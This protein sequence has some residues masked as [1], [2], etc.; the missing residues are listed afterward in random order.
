VVLVVITVLAGIVVAVGLAGTTGIVI[1]V[2]LAVLLGLGFAVVAAWITTKLAFVPSV[3][4][5]ERRGI[6]DAVRRSWQLTAGAFWKTFGIILLVA[7]IL[8]IATQ[9]ITVPLQLLPGLLTQV[10]APTGD[11]S[12]AVAIGVTAAVLVF[13]LTLL[14]SALSIVVQSA[15][16]VLLYIDQR[17]RKEGLDLEI[18]RFVEAGPDGG[19][20]EDPFL[21]MPPG[22]DGPVGTPGTAP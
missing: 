2:V 5:L 14:L 15:T 21:R 11:E 12:V 20:V 17:F 16:T 18:A 3:I 22:A 13:I 6:R 8:S 1:A 19:G 4:V 7:A 10:L 9:V